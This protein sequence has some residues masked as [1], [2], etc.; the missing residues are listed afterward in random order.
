MKYR[1]GFQ[2]E[3]YNL[4]SKVVDS[5]ILIF[6]PIGAGFFSWFTRLRIVISVRMR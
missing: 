5:P 4:Q 3:N 2:K 6:E 1:D